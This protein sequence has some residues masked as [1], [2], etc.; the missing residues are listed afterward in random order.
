MSLSEP[1]VFDEGDMKRSRSVPV[2]AAVPFA[3]DPE[4]EMPSNHWP[5][6]FLIVGAITFAAL[7][8]GESGPV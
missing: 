1:G 5:D 6:Q 4:Y 7:S 8:A 3:Y 2:A